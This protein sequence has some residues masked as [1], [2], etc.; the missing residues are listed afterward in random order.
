MSHVI[1]D[2]LGMRGEVEI[3]EMTARPVFDKDGNIVN[4]EDI[5]K[6]FP[7]QNTIVYASR[8][9]IAKLRSDVGYTTVKKIT[10]FAMG[11]G[12]TSPPDPPS[13]TDVALKNQTWVQ[14]IPDS[15]ITAPSTVS[16]MFT[17]VVDAG[18]AT[19]LWNE[20]A[21]KLDDDTLFS[22]VTYETQ[23]KDPDIFLIFRW[24][25]VF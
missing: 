19:G 7:K 25:I 14:D 17:S 21:M 22:R 12:E 11:D 2:D 23:Q 15:Q 10:Q 8:A 16:R 20:L 1:K 18:T 6:S 9:E 13:P 24:V 3:I 4:T 5:L